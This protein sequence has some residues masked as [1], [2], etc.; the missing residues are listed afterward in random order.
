MNIK[1]NFRFFLAS[2]LRL[3]VCIRY[4]SKRNA[5]CFMPHR[6]MMMNDMYDILNYKSDNALSLAHYMLENKLEE[7]SPF[8][9]IVA[10]WESANRL[11]SIL[12]KKYPNKE[13]ILA[14]LL[15]F[16]ENV[17][18]A[19]PYQKIINRSKYIF[20]SITYNLKGFTDKN[21]ILVDLNY[22]TVPFK[23]D[24]YTP[25]DPFYMKLDRLGHEYNAYVCTSELSI[26]VIMP[27][28]T[29]PYSKYVLLGMCRNDYLCADGNDIDLRS[30]ILSKVDYHV[31]KIW[32]YTPTHRDYENKNNDVSRFLLGFSA[33]M[34]EL[35]SF[36]KRNH[37]LILCKL[38]PK[39]NKTIISKILPT[40]ILVHQPNHE[41]GLTEL[42]RISDGLITDYTSGYF[43]Y[44][45]LD[46]PVIFNFY[47]VEKYVESRGF[48]YNPIESITAGDIIKDEESFKT[49]LLN[50]DEN[51]KNYAFKR[52]FVKDLFFTYQDTNNCERVYNYFFR[53]QKLEK[54]Q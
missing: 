26:R 21:Q 11:S 35:D 29:L 53:N 41:Y 1:D 54:E 6:G 52:K 43:D 34:S 32:L 20:T 48:T 50:I 12:I 38:H 37:I 25:S 44:L 9:F 14:P 10:N 19:I 51:R 3:Y 33:D 13:F 17:K 40:S 15:T 45:L 18:D 39:Q 7:K 4:R 42:M 30:R 47:D 24:I 49:A 23:N 16:N 8:C 5:I 2:I 46:K 28:M 27:T 36:L 22:F 31:E